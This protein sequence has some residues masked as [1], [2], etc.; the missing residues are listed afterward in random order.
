[1]VKSPKSL[2]EFPEKLRFGV[3]GAGKRFSMLKMSWMVPRT[4]ISTLSAA[5]KRTPTTPSRVRSPSSP[6]KPEK[7]KIP[8]G[9]Q[10]DTVFRLKGQGIVSLNGYGK[11]DQ[12]VRVKVATPK[13]LTKE[14]KELFKQLSAISG[15]S[16]E[17]S[18]LFEKVKE[19]LTTQDA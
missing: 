6:E 19:I 3:L 4:W 9:T 11:G 5:P 18:S 12:L 17:S 14:Q 16:E 10:S 15:D 13:K 2:V 1:M 7:I 8:A